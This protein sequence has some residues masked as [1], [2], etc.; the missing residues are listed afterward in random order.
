MR[1]S[2]FGKRIISEKTEAVD[3]SKSQRT[4]RIVERPLEDVEDIICHNRDV[5]VIVDEA[6]VDF[7]G[8]SLQSSLIEKYDNLLVVQ[9]FSKIPFSGRN[10]YRLMP[11]AMQG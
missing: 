10:A 11:V 8:T 5:V 2:T 3:L 6:Y 1:I 9:T 7:G 4:N